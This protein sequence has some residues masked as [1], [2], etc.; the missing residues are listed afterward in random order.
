MTTGVYVKVKKPILGHFLYD[1][2]YTINVDMK[3]LGLL[4]TVTANPSADRNVKE[5]VSGQGNIA[6]EI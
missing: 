3:I 6:K 4:S 5:A 1:S 2:S